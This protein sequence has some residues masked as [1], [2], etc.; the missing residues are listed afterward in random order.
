MVEKMKLLMLSRYGRLGASSRLRSMQYVPSLKEVGIQVCIEPLFSDSYVSALK[1]GRRD[2]LL[3]VFCYL[4]RFF[5]LFRAR[6]YDVIWIEK[7][8]LPWM[9]SWVE[10]FFLRRSKFILDFDDAIFHKYDMH[11][12]GL[13][14]FFL[15]RKIDRLMR[16]ANLVVCGNSYLCERARSAGAEWVELIPTVIDIDRYKFSQPVRRK[17]ESIKIVW[18][19]SPS[20]GKYLSIIQDPLVRLSRV[21]KLK[22]IVIGCNLQMNGVDVELV[23]WSEDS[24]V[25]SIAVGSIGVMPLVDSPWERGKCGYKLIQYMGVSLPVVASPV[26]VNC[27]IVQNGVNGYLAESAD[28]WCEK[29]SVLLSNEAL[30]HQMGGSGRRIVENDY[31]IQ[32]TSLRLARLILMVGR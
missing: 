3:V 2:F 7:E 6:R 17:D 31:C 19:G 27:E 26:G 23:P 4:R 20:T 10:L 16:R 8:A 30:R 28:E 22:L 15:G 5:S 32:R 13:V 11:R 1:Y 24:E 25:E 9:P 29:L 21:F 14:R 18:I 12:F